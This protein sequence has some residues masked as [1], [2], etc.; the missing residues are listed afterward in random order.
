[1]SISDAIIKASLTKGV[2]TKDEFLE[3]KRRMSGEAGKDMPPTS[4]LRKA[5]DKAVAA[6]PANRNDALDTLLTR[7]GVR[8][9]SGVTVITVL[10]KPYACPGHCVYCPTESIMPKSYLSNEPAAMRALMNRFDPWKQVSQRLRALTN[11]GHEADKI[12]LI[13]KGGTWSAYPWD[14]Q[15]R[16]IKRCFDA[17]N[18][19]QAQGAKRVARR[20]ATLAAAQDINENANHRIIGITLETRPDWITPKEIVRLREL[21]CTRVELGVQSIDDKLLALTKRG[22]TV[23]AVVRAARLLKDSGFKTDFHMMPQLPGA[24]AAS[25]LAELTE[26]FDNPDFR[27]DMIKIY[28]CVTVELAELHEW[29]KDG[30]YV[31]YPDAELVETLITAKTRIPRYCRISRLIRDIPST[32]IVAGNVV[33]NLRQTVQAEMAKR[34]LACACLRCREIGRV[35]QADP[36]LMHETPTYFDDVYEASGGEEHFMSYE[37]SARR[38]VF[39]FC[40]LRLPAKTPQNADVQEIWN[41]FPV[42]Q[43]AAF[44]RELHTYGHLVPVDDHDVDASQHKGLG[45][46]LMAEAERIAAAAGYEKLA[47]ISGIG[48]RA[49]YRKLGYAPDG[50]YMV[51]TLK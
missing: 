5:Y 19:F 50:T 39:A 25:D 24:T 11:N 12:E 28:P 44:I 17:A 51:K 9:L 45:K 22:H 26:I 13:V 8:S 6:D 27:P 14:Y 20:T 43:D 36:S 41:S 1:M 35:A 31:P 15:Q 38:A 47:V 2:Q 29:W 23:D 48:V 37:D 4:A 7:R 33:T 30:R 18:A 40:R 42:L 16:F 32:S 3:C 10:T 46:K 34:G 49:Y 21:G